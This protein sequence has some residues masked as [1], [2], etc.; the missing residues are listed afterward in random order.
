LRAE[1]KALENN[2]LFRLQTFTPDQMPAAGR[3]WNQVAFGEP[4]PVILSAEKPADRV[5]S[6]RSGDAKRWSLE[7]RWLEE[8]RSELAGQW[9]ALDGDRLIAHGK[10][11]R[12]VYAAAAASG[13]HLPLVLQVE[14]LDELPF[15][16]W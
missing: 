16:G 7:Q 6:K 13:V 3:P 14:P 5:A 1:R 4:V 12:D 8:H 2:S 11:A 9:V 15:E 10:N